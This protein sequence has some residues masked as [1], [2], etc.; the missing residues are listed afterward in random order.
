MD[1]LP[2]FAA[3]AAAEAPSDRV[4]DGEDIRHLFHGRFD[5]ADLN[6]AF[7]YYLRVHLQAVRQGKWKLVG[8]DGEPWQLYD[9][10]VDRT[11]TRDLAERSPE[12]ARRLSGLYGRWAE[13]SDVLP[14]DELKIPFIPP[15]ENPLT[16]TEEELG[17]YF[18][19]LEARGIEVP[20]AEREK[21]QR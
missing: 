20:F 10:E 7:F 16:R 21:Q 1:I 9:M 11:E 3:L 12:V 18:S 19:E 5:D 13:R 4:I 2:T 15:S 8:A 14:W 6:K 17:R